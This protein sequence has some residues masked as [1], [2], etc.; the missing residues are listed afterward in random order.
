MENSVQ[1]REVLRNYLAGSVINGNNSPR[2]NDQK[3]AVPISYRQNLDYN[4]PSDLFKE[5]Q[6][7]LKLQSFMFASKINMKQNQTP[8]NRRPQIDTSVQDSNF[9]STIKS[10][11]NSSVQR[12]PNERGIGRM[13][14]LAAIKQ[15]FYLDIQDLKNQCKNNYYVK[16]KDEKLRIFEKMQDPN[17]SNPNLDINQ[18]YEQR[19]YPLDLERDFNSKNKISVIDQER[20]QEIQKLKELESKFDG[21]DRDFQKS[22][23]RQFNKQ[24]QRLNDESEYKYLRDANSGFYRQRKF[25][26]DKHRDMISKYIKDDKVQATTAKIANQFRSGGPT[27]PKDSQLSSTHQSLFQKIPARVVST[28]DHP[29]RLNTY[30]SEFESSTKQHKPVVFNFAKFPVENSTYIRSDFQAKREIRDKILQ[31]KNSAAQKMDTLN[32]SMPLIWKQQEETK[33]MIERIK[34]QTQSRKN[35]RQLSLPKSVQVSPRRV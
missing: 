13:S 33:K 21:E 20:R 19:Y 12:S 6:K 18:H 31:Y 17:Q 5:R 3:Q 2:L 9:D 26:D 32:M 23:E 29:S 10:K 8:V 22:L 7:Q 28:T 1:K 35:H 16:D 11:L 14:P 27:S 30:Q 34:E 4:L 24:A 25:S 15:Q